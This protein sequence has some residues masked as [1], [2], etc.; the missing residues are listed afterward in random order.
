[1]TLLVTLL[2]YILIAAV[3]WWAISLLPLPAPFGLIVR[4]VFAV[5]VVVFLLNLLA[6]GGL[7]L[8]LR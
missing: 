3:I 8:P 6:G 5:V 4:V 7:G 2:I 1:M